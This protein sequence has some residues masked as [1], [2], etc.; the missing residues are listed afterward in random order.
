MSDFLKKQLRENVVERVALLFGEFMLEEMS[1]IK[2]EGG[3]KAFMSLLG[4]E[5]QL[6]AEMNERFLKERMSEE[7]MDK[8]ADEELQKLLAVFSSF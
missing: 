5:E 6:V 4:T 2:T 7:I 1:K 3:K 8:I